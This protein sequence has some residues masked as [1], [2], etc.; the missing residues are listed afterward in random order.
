MFNGIDFS[1]LLRL[2]T[3]DKYDPLLFS[4]SF[5]LFLFLGFLIFYRIFINRRNA[6]ITLLLIFSFYFYYK[7]SGI[8]FLILFVSSVVNY[9]AGIL[10]GTGTV[11]SKRKFWFILAV[12]VN[13]ALLGYFK[14][15]NFFVRIINDFSISHINALDIFIPIGISFY[16]FKALSYIIDVFW[17]NLKP[18]RN[19][20]YFCLYISFF[21]NV[22][23]G[24]IDRATEFLPQIR[25][26]VHISKAQ[27]GFAIYLIISGLFKKVVIAD[28]IS[29][30]FVDRVF[31]S[32][33]RFTGLENLLSVYGYALQ[34][35][36]DFSGYSDM[37]IGIAMLLGFRLMDNFDS[38]YQAKSVAEF[39]RRWHISLSTWLLDYLFRPLQ[40]KF[41][42]WRIYGNSLALLITF[43]L[44]G[45][46]HGA[47]WLFV[48]W[49]TLHGL[50]MV[51]SL[52][53]QKARKS[54]YNR[55]GIAGSK[56]LKA[57]QVFI[58]FHLVAFAWLFF[59]ADSVTNVIH[60][61][62]QIFS[63]FHG[64]V[65]PQ[66]ISGYPSIFAL[67]IIGYL[68]HFLPKSFE[69]KTQ[70]LIANM[71]LI[72]QALLLTFAIWLV[73][74]VKSAALQPFI[75]FKF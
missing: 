9:Y 28:Y 65:F 38:P 23:A 2:F 11:N 12:I 7:V 71:P 4:T 67:L 39:W 49:G 6:R 58:T 36:C 55:L 24:P 60:M 27:M 59:R 62:K 19:F 35:Y 5:F 21:P 43:A 40:M 22:L 45:L 29:L 48:F 42:N 44:C 8:F 70:N 75:Y 13:L 68:L 54:F 3:F 17:E 63:F 16:T 53:T 56:Y 69:K 74:Q 14:Y 15:T 18:E 66:F 30:N 41:R 52:F 33:L 32:P 51:V 31:Q 46:W 57:F 72:G 20:A 26:E 10:I 34:I 64:E 47:N 61:L 37:A 25:K 1:K 73:I 50:F